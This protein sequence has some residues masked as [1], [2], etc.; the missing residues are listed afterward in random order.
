MSSADSPESPNV[1]SSQSDLKKSD[2]L[3][4]DAQDH[5]LQDSSNQDQRIKQLQQRLKEHDLTLLSQ[6]TYWLKNTT[7]TN[8][9]AKSVQQPFVLIVS[10]QQTAGRGQAG[11]VWQSPEGNLYLSLRWTLQHPLSGRLALEIAL[12]LVNMPFLKHQTGLQIKWPNDLY[13]NQAKWGGILIEPVNHAQQ[14]A[15]PEHH[16][17]VII[18]VGLN[19]LAMQAQVQD[20]VV[21]DLSQIIDHLPDQ[22][23]LILQT[24][25]ALIEACHQFEHGSIDLPPR[26]ASFDA[27]LEK[28]VILHLAG[29]ADISGIMR[30]V[31]SD[32]A[33]LLE[34][35]QGMQVVYSGQVR[36]V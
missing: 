35:A 18:G 33:L 9:I 17:Q 3:K 7:S 8:E 26:F 16:S 10:N 14:Q 21:T 23:T 20:Q 19:L 1:S 6:H 29:Q 32:G 28:P 11:R 34:T 13:F 31:Q 36:P 27:L 2:L 12:A 25:I 4:S 30:G 15:Q 22:T 24:T 5:A